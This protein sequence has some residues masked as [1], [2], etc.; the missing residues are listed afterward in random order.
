MTTAEFCSEEQ[1]AVVTAEDQ[2]ILMRGC[3][4]SRKTDTL[5]RI[6]VRH[7]LA[8]RNVLIV[9][10][11]GSVT[12]ELRER[13]EGALPGCEFQRAGNHHMYEPPGGGP[14]IEIANYD[15]MLH[16]Q[17][18]SH[19]DPIVLRY[20]ACFTRKATVML[21]KYV[22]PGLHRA[23]LLR[24]GAAADVLLMDEFQD[25]PPAKARILTGVL[26]THGGMRAVAAGDHVQSIFDHTFVEEEPHP[27]DIWRDEL[28]AA[29]YWMTKC[30]RCPRAHVRL[31]NRLLAP[32]MEAHRITEMVAASDDDFHRPLMFACPNENANH[33]AHA[34]A[35]QVCAVLAELRA[36]AE[37]GLRPEDVAIIMPRSNRNP[38][39]HQLALGLG[40]LYASWG[41]TARE[42]VAL[43][44]TRGDNFVRP[45]DWNL[46]VG[47]TV[48]LSVHGDKGKGHKVVFFLGLS[49]GVV[50]AAGR[51]YTEKELIDLSLL[52]VALTRSTRWLFVG[53][54]RDRPSRYVRDVCEELDDV[55]ALAWKDNEEEDEVFKRLAAAC[56]TGLEH[57]PAGWR[58]PW[59]DND[60][61]IRR[62]IRAPLRLMAQVRDDVAS[63][64]EHPTDLVASY[65]WR[66]A[67]VVRFGQPVV[68][69]LPE[70]RLACFGVMGELVF[71]REY[72]RRRGRMDTL[73]ADI[74]FLLDP[75]A[76]FFTRNERLLAI[77][78]DERFNSGIATMPRVAFAVAVTQLAARYKER[79]G[80]KAVLELQRVRALGR[81]VRIAPAFLSS[82]RLME[83]VAAF[84][85]DV[86]THELSPRAV[87]NCALVRCVLYDSVSA[88]GARAWVDDFNHDIGQLLANA[89]RL[90]DLLEAKEL[91]F[92]VPYRLGVT[93]W[94]RETLDDMGVFED[95]AHLGI[96]GE[97]DFESDTTVFEVKC[98]RP[99]GHAELASAWIIQPLMYMCFTNAKSA[100]SV[101]DM[102]NGV[103]YEYGE[104][105]RLP[106]AR[107]IRDVLQRLRHREEHVRAIMMA[108]ST[109]N[110]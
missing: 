88:P 105:E 5:V 16:T 13:L 96:S 81:P 38:V 43:F 92:H 2:Y 19:N 80:A 53:V 40:R 45:I 59:F 100:I 47:R 27:M 52:N 15:A 61:Y 17:L 66:D 84:L 20:G 37:P 3:A 22:R 57:L 97:A 65:P 108:R 28:G 69:P 101:I 35:R 34:I 24:N 71:Q 109:K 63:M 9:T 10:L 70:E 54:S 95:G 36:T 33:T 73:R 102:T 8:G 25:L 6:C 86:P 42:T 50:P 14:C 76:V 89:E 87:W 49:E 23:F 30:F 83:D 18:A 60:R 107:I 79:A 46:A 91:A 12:M 41:F 21:D 29:C 72:C 99:N 98:P 67:N 104:M 90:C 39:F 51:L 68:F 31:V 77:L 74:G 110:Q 4:G 62:R 44:E 64:Y 75:E 103:M 26:R 58:V 55:C 7:H 93:E 85:S 48:L 1:R 11:V 56:L 106:R 94:N 82:E 32:H 78:Q